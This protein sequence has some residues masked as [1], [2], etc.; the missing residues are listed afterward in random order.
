MPLYLEPSGFQIQDP[1]VRGRTDPRLQQPSPTVSS[2]S[3]LLLAVSQG[4]FKTSVSGSPCFLALL[5]YF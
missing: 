3:P 4:I 2:L 1:G 5:Y